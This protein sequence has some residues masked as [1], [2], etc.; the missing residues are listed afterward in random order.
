[1][2]KVS[3]YTFIFTAMLIAAFMLSC[4]VSTDGWTAGP[5]SYGDPGSDGFYSGPP[6]SSLAY[7]QLDTEITSPNSGYSVP[8]QS[9]VWV[10]GVIYRSETDIDFNPWDGPE[11]LV[12]NYRIGSS[13]YRF[14][15]LWPEVHVRFPLD[16]TVIG[17][18]TH[19]V[20]LKAYDRTTGLTTPVSDSISI[21]FY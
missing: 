11:W 7:G 5:I 4:S 17:P 20:T 21:T 6:S 9:V 1:M 13:Y 16:G 8:F 2:Y 19:T 14:D 15:Q 18:G 3:K 12:D 10:H